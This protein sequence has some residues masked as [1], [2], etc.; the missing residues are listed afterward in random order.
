[1]KYYVVLTQW[2][3]SKDMV[4]FE[5]VYTPAIKPVEEFEEDL[6]HEDSGQDFHKLLTVLEEKEVPIE[7]KR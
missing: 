7:F 6:E 5:I 4:Y 1:M 3:D 2:R